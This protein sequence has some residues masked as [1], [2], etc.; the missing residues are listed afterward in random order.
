M[1]LEELK[2]KTKPKKKKRVGRGESG[3]G[4]KTAGRGHKGQKARSGGKPHPLFE[5]GQTPLYQRLPKIKG[6]KNIFKKEW[7]IVNVEQLNVFEG[8]TQVTPEL[9][10]EKG[11]VKKT[12]QLIKILGRGNISK[13][14][15]VVADAFSSSA[16]EKI[17]KA[18]GK[19]ILR[20][21]K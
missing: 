14:L 15:E 2:P 19:V 12:N 21:E 11:F 8:G 16:K 13:K 5:G 9:L 18:G 6:F 3:K 7:E 10:V 17:E 20:K 4:G 1:N